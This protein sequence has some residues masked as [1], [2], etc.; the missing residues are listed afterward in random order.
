[1]SYSTLAELLAAKPNATLSDHAALIEPIAG[2][3]A[4]AISAL[5][6]ALAEETALQ[7]AVVTKAQ[8]VLVSKGYT[9]TV[10]MEAV[11]SLRSALFDTAAL[12]SERLRTACAGTKLGTAVAWAPVAEDKTGLVT[13]AQARIAAVQSTLNRWGA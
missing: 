5:A 11:H 10:L 3:K 12:T 1:M 2:R 9:G 8:A 6:S 13:D 7:D 4:A